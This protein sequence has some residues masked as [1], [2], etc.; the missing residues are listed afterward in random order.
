M[1]GD[2]VITTPLPSAGLSGWIAGR[3]QGFRFE[4]KVY[5]EHALQPAFEIA[6]SRI[7]KLELRRLDTGTVAY[8][9]D[10]GLDRPAEDAEAQT[11][12]VALAERLANLVY[13]PAGG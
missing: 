3:I 5:P 6:K 9:W 1:D 2:L 11:A 7:S 10:R 12:V 4:A 13:G 8:A